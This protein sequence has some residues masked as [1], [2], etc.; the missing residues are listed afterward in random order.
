MGTLQRI[1]ERMGILPRTHNHGQRICLAPWTS[2]NFTIDGHVS[3]CCLNRVT[4]IPLAGRTLLD[5]WNGP[6]FQKLRAHVTEGDLSYDCSV[7]KAQF[8]AGNRAGL[9]AN[10]YQ[11]FAPP[12]PR[13]PKVME[14]CLDNT[15][16]LACTMCNSVLSST[17]RKERG[18][19]PHRRLYDDS[20]VKGLEPFIP[21]LQE[22]VFSGGE[23]FLIPLYYRIWEMMVE[24]NP[25]IIISVVT[26]GTML[27]DRIREL[28]ERGRFRINVSID[29]VNPETYAAIRR[30]ADFEKVMRNFQWY[31][32]YGERKGL[33]VNI[34]VCLLTL[35]WPELPQIVRFANLQNVSV[36]F[37]HVDRPVN[38]ALLYSERDVL[39]K[40]LSSLEKES[41]FANND[42]AVINVGRFKGV[43]DEIAELCLRTELE[44]KGIQSFREGHG[45]KQQCSD[46]II[47]Q[48]LPKEVL[49]ALDRIPVQDCQVILEYL[50]RAPFERIEQF[51]SGKTVDETMVILTELVGEKAP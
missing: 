21:H 27:N 10:D 35:N 6:E 40:V 29:S 13:F 22:A 20:F 46:D 41:I 44:E 18:L 31:R 30:N 4:S 38:L 15:C 36:N 16:N 14:F 45:L 39:L 24:L 32:E 26:N 3:V 47:G 33:R 42:V 7:C 8:D 12:H 25:D 48:S 51:F 43:I 2:M 50:Q 5:I 28:L 9:K 17:I 37:V 19:P 49:L 34:P 23:P 11:K 1:G